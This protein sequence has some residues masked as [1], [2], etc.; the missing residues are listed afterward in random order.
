MGHPHLIQ[1]L[2][3]WNADFLGEKAAEILVA[4]SKAIRNLIEGNRL[5][6]VFSDVGDD[7]F[8]TAL[9]FRRL[10]KIIPVELDGKMRQQLEQNMKDQG[11]DLDPVA[12]GTV[13][14]QLRQFGERITDFQIISHQL[15]G[16]LCPVTDDLIIALVF[17]ER[18]NIFVI[19]MDDKL[20]IILGTSELMDPAGVNDDELPLDHGVSVSLRSHFSPAVE[21]ICDLKSGVPVCRDIR[22]VSPEINSRV[23]I[24]QF[25]FGDVNIGILHWILHAF[26]SFIAQYP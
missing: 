21:K 20:H 22:T 17:H 8:D 6:V 14:A 23:L 7:L 12:I 9:V 19:D 13:D 10:R 18:S 5:C 2:F 4:E 25:I 16:E 24:D 15:F 26:L 1:M 11:L 3:K